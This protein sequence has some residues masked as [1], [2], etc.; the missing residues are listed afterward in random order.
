MDPQRVLVIEDDR[1]IAGLLT[2]ILTEAGYAVTA[3]GTALGAMATVRALEPCAVLLDLGLPYRSGASLL[4]EL[5]ADPDAAD[6]L[7]IVVSS[8]P[9]LVPV[10]RRA[11][12]AAVI[13]K[14]FEV[15]DLVDT[16]GASCRPG[17]VRQP[18]GAA[19]L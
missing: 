5:K 18:V 7:V 9:D 14:P 11:L 13:Q 12:A 8:M 2:Q 15:Q 17:Q 4:A 16:V 10:Q 1:E 6:T 19:P 3:T